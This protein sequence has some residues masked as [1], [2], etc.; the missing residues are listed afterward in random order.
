ML[1]LTLMLS[2]AIY[3]GLVI[4]SERAPDAPAPGVEVTRAADPVAA[5]PPRAAVGQ[6]SL[7]TDDGRVLAVA[8]VIDPAR[9][10]PAA[11]GI[12]AIST[13][14]AP[15]PAAPLPAAAPVASGLALAEVTGTQVNLRA[16]PSTGEAVLASLTR[17]M[18]VELIAAP[19][20]GWA[21]IRAVETG[22]EGYMADRFL[23][24]LR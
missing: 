19:A 5:V 23:G 10:D 15:D 21:H 4:F 20:N 14:S 2:A 22:V 24:S 3:A 7:T 18:R 11:E 16:G 9:I 6:R 13:L 8:A 17:G 1:R 12:A